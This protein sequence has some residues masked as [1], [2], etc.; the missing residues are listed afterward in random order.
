MPRRKR[1]LECEYR[2]LGW[3]CS[4]IDAW[5]TAIYLLVSLLSPSVVG[6]FFW[7]FMKGEVVGAFVFATCV[8]AHNSAMISTAHL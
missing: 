5:I 8:A 6:A 2:M 7:K 4:G 3:W 1:L